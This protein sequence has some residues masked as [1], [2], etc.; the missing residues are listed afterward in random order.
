MEGEKMIEDK[1]TE[2]SDYCEC[3]HCKKIFMFLVLLLLSFIAGIMVGNCQS[4]T[5]SYI[6]PYYMQNAA[7]HSS[8]MK[9]KK[10]HRGLQQIEHQN[11]SNKQQQPNAQMGGFIVEVEQGD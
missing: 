2:P 1:R 9:Q 10:Y 6:P 11:N 4:T 8:S 5:Y 7:M 3:C